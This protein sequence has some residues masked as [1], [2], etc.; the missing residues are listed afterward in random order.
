MRDEL[1]VFVTDPNFHLSDHL[2]DDKFLTRLPY[3]GDV[4]S[5]L[6][7]LN[8]GL[9]GLSATITNVRDKIEAVIKKLELFSVCINRDN[10]QVFPSLYDLLCANELKLTDNVKCD[11]ANHLNELGTQLRE[12][13]TEM[14]D[15]N[16]CI[17]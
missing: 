10:T 16:N 6:N 13:F 15:T 14:D 4:F 9:Q 8:L 11:I 5:R 2:H 1:K 7:D 12:Y 17:C 3:L